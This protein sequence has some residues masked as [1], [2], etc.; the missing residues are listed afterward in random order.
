MIIVAAHKPV[1]NDEVKK[2]GPRFIDTS[3]QQSIRRGFA[4]YTPRKRQRLQGEV[5]GERRMQRDP[6]EASNFDLLS[7]F[8][9]PPRW[10]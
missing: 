1:P 9:R 10:E 3:S 2:S 7:R 8:C 4:R 6:R 5:G